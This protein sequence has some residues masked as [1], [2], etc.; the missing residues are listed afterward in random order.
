MYFPS[1]P[2]T[3]Q[4]TPPES[5]SYYSPWIRDSNCK[6]NRIVF[7][8]SSKVRTT[9]SPCPLSR[10]WRRH[11][12]QGQEDRERDED[13]QFIWRDKSHRWELIHETTS[14]V[15]S[16]SP[17]SSRTI[18]NCTNHM[19]ERERGKETYSVQHQLFRWFYV[20]KWSPYLWWQPR[21]RGGT[22]AF[23]FQAKRTN[24][25]GQDVRPEDLHKQGRTFTISYLLNFI[26]ISSSSSSSGQGRKLNKYVL[27]P[28][29][30]SSSRVEE[31]KGGAEQ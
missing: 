4:K 1:S 19:E 29:T 25:G 31:P 26:V 7:I 8:Q 18:R 9:A 22:E 5:P 2:W 23:F 14:D 15:V 11:L 20:F 13:S 27:P 12:S 10:A 30:T 16:S 6:A 17:P 28:S 3:P 21:T 24:Q